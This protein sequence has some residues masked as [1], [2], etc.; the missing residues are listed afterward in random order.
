MV[1]FVNCAKMLCEDVFSMIKIIG[2]KPTISILKSSNYRTKYTIR[3]AQKS[4][5]FIEDIR[6]IK[7]PE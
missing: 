7:K 1:N 6:L 4:K 2:Y 5:E 3:V